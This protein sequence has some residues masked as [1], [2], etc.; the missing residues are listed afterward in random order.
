[1]DG[2]DSV[3]G[4]AEGARLLP[5]LTSMCTGPDEA[6][7]L[8]GSYVAIVPA[9]GGS[10]S[11]AARAIAP[12]GAV[13]G[14]GAG[15]GAGAQQQAAQRAEGDAAFR[16]YYREQMTV[17]FGEQLAGL[18]NDKDFSGNAKSLAALVHCME[19]GAHDYTAAEKRFL[20]GRAAATKRR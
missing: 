16:A 13:A 18:R 6:A 12:P 4:G 8:A 3:E 1:M 20:V 10:A 5:L 15:A 19:S 2:I 9:A 11:D 7:A 17:A 14:A